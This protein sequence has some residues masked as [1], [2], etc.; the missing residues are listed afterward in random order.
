M[1]ARSLLVV[2]ASLPM[3][4]VGC[5]EEQSGEYVSPTGFQSFIY[6]K[7]GQRITYTMLDVISEDGPFVRYVTKQ[8]IAPGGPV[9]GMVNYSSRRADCDKLLFMSL[10]EGDTVEKMRRDP[11]TNEW[12]ELVN[13]SS[14]TAAVVTACQVTKK[15]K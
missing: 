6:K 1:R 8:Q 7:D 12:V 10:G 3:L 11:P 13:G 15:L 2:T 9:G 5:G 14:A 4:L